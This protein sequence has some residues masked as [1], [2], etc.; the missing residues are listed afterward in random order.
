MTGSLKVSGVPDE[1]RRLLKVR[2][3]ARGW[4]TR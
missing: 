4:S 1:H 2:A 3:A